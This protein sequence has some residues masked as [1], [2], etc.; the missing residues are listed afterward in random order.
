[1]DTTKLPDNLT[2]L[3]EF[4]NQHVDEAASFRACAEKAR[5]D[6][7]RIDWTKRADHHLRVA[8]MAHQKIRSIRSGL[9][10]TEPVQLP[11]HRKL[12]G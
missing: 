10:H 8:E 12:K 11:T 3:R 5:T 7:A 9:S 6:V 1:M 2:E 4:F